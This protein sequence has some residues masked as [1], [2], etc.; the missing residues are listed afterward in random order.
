VRTIL[1]HHLPQPDIFFNQSDDPACD[2]HGWEV[3]DVQYRAENY[4]MIE[5][6]REYMSSTDTERIMRQMEFIRES[7]KTNMFDQNRVT[8]IAKNKKLEEL[9]QHLENMTRSDYISFLT[10]FEPYAVEYRSDRNNK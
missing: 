4:L 10:D 3:P 1:H 8:E 7:G 6:N 9:H 5:P 2:R